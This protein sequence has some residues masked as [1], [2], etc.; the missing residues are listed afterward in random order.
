M[1]SVCEV[2]RDGGYG[3]FRWL[4]IVRGRVWQRRGGGEGIAAPCPGWRGWTI[5]VYYL[6]MASTNSFFS[7]DDN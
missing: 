6:A 5:H 3:T 7:A 2:Y 4:R 1:F